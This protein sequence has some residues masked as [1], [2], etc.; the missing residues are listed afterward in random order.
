LE[1][2][3]PVFCTRKL[4]SLPLVQR[5]SANG[6]KKSRNA[7]TELTEEGIPVPNIPLEAGVAEV[8]SVCTDASMFGGFDYAVE[9]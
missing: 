2:A 7:I 1:K 9:R 3:V 6:R 4:S 5:S 8:D